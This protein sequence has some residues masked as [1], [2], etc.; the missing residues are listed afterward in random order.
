[1]ATRLDGNVRKATANSVKAAQRSAESRKCPECQ[2]K[3]A[4]VY[5]ND[6]VVAGSECR[7]CGFARSIDL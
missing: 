5:F 3:S 1:M 2:R 4:M 6:G 7:W